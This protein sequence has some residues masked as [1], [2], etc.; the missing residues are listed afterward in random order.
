MTKTKN[1]E[2]NL[3]DK[4]D[5]IMMEDFNADNLKIDQ[6]ILQVKLGD[7]E[8]AEDATAL[9]FTL[10]NPSDYR[11][12]TVY[13]TAS[14]SREMS[15]T[16]NGEEI[17]SMFSIN[18]SPNPIVG[19]ID[20]VLMKDRVAGFSQQVMAA[21]NTVYS[22]TGSGLLQNVDLSESLTIGVHSIEDRVLNTGSTLEVY[23]MK[24]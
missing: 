11:E 4:T 18:Y 22:R 7:A 6:A 24:R 2:L 21:N 16:V 20:L 9:T 12:L 23:G 3:W 13:Y 17:C 19:K 1:F 10:E 8:L 14:G 15:L 5:R